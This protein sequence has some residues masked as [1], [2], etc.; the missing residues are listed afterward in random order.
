MRIEAKSNALRKVRAARSRKGSQWARINDLASTPLVSSTRNLK[1][2]FRH[3]AGIEYR[4]RSGRIFLSLLF[5]V[6]FFESHFSN[7]ACWRCLILCHK[8]LQQV[9][10][11]VVGK[12]MF[13]NKI[14][15]MMRQLFCLDLEWF[16]YEDGRGEMNAKIV[17]LIVGI[18]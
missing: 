16:P 1:T 7:N 2:K 12:L 5:V 9:D 11:L 10:P 18:N 8:Y 3:V 6:N 4:K 13:I 14:Y 15:S 17:E